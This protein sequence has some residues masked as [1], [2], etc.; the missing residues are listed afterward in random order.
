MANRKQR[1]QLSGLDE[2]LRLE[3]LRAT[4]QAVDLYS[5]VLAL[6]LKDKLGFGPV[7]AQRFLK[8]VWQLFNDV[9]NGYL[10]LED[11][12]ET[13]RDELRINIKRGLRG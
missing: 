9:E 7:R 6:T 10:S 2:L 11:I 1:R 13:V 8:D 4:E 5:A 12:Q 3:G